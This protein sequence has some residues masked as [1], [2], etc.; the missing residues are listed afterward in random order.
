MHF[1]RLALSNFGSF[2]NIA[3]EFPPSGV[4]VISGANAS[5][6]SQRSAR[7]WLQS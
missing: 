2:R 4:S 6:K 3:V 5:G 1:I 7:R